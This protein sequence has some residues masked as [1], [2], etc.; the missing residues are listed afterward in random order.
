MNNKDINNQDH[1]QKVDKAASV[2]NST[3]KRQPRDASENR[4]EKKSSNSSMSE[5]NQL[6]KRKLTGIDLT[7]RDDLF[8]LKYHRAVSSVYAPANRPAW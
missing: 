7:A 5:N 4:G 8:E 2:G 6:E 3:K 1:P